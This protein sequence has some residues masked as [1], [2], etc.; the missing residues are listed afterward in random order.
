M[1]LTEIETIS[2]GNLEIM[3]PV[4]AEKLLRAG[5]TAGLGPG[6][7]VLD[8]GCGN[9]TT[10]SL[11][12]RAFGISGC[13]IELRASSAARAGTTLAGTSIEIRCIDAAALVPAEPYDLV[14]ALGSSFIFGGAEKSLAHLAEYADENGSVIIIGDRFWKRDRVPPEFAR[15]W[16]D[17]PTAFELISTGRDLGFDLT[18]L[19]TASDDDWDNYESAIWQNCREY[20]NSRTAD[21]RADE[22]A[23]YLEQIQDEYLAYGREYMGWGLFIFRQ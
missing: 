15:E 23:A 1:D 22:V 3:N 9:G 19:I 16:P 11:W 4:S 17:V 12:H 21:P 5:Q 2:Q 10:L 6:K 13:G 7:K 18:G 8:I 20:I 14:T